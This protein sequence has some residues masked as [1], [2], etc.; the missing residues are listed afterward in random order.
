[1]KIGGGE[2]M[3]PSKIQRLVASEFLPQLP[4]DEFL[5]RDRYADTP[6]KHMPDQE[7]GRGGS[8]VR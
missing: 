5:L 6:R 2:M 3:L 7:A 1:M 4:Q 8:N